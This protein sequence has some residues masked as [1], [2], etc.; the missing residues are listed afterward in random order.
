MKKYFVLAL[1]LMAFAVAPVMADVALSGEFNYSAS[2][3]TDDSIVTESVDKMELD[4]AATLDDYNTFKLELEDDGKDYDGSAKASII[5]EALTVNYAK[6]MTDW[7]KYFGFAESGFGVESTVGVFDAETKE[8]ADFTGYNFEY[9]YTDL[10][11]NNTFMFDFDI[12]DGMVK[13]YYAQ[14]FDTYTSNKAFLIGSVVEVAPVTA[15]LYYQMEGETDGI[16][17]IFGFEAAYSG[18]V[19]DGVVLNVAGNVMMAKGAHAGQAGA[20]VDGFDAAVE[21]YEEINGAGSWTFGGVEGNDEMN[22][23]YGFGIGAEAYGAVIN[24]SFWGAFLGS[25]SADIADGSYALSQLGIDA[26][27]SILEWLGVNAG[28]LFNLGDFKDDFAGEEAFAGAEFGVSIM[29][30]AVT[31]QLGFVAAND[32][33][34]NYSELQANGFSGKGGL[35]FVVDLDY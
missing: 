2:Y 10:G 8:T 21:A 28:M 19:S 34:G 17:N 7:G 4:F 29:P 15:E 20:L 9:G 18:E 27:Y 11:T 14:K 22:T 6:V 26:E 25:D 33:A 23:S 12:A 24:T 13:P 35:Y 16:G 31:Y 32:D 1:A 5:D 3:N 30:G